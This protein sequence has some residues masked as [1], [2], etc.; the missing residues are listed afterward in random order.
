MYRGFKLF[1]ALMVGACTL[2]SVNAQSL[3]DS[4]FADSVRME[5]T[6]RPVPWSIQLWDGRAF[7][8]ERDSDRR[9]EPPIQLASVGISALGSPEWNFSQG[10]LG[11]VS[12][13]GVP[14]W[15]NAIPE[16][17]DQWN[18]R[19]GPL[20]VVDW[21]GKSAQGRGQEFGVV[22]SASPKYFQHFWVDFRRLQ[23]SGGLLTE[24]H[25]R[26]RLRTAFWGRDSARKWNYSIQIGLQRTVDGEAG[27]VVDTRQ[28]TEADFWQPNRD[29]VTTRWSQA[30]RVGQSAEVRADWIHARSRLGVELNWSQNRS[31]FKGSGVSVDSVEY[32]VIDARVV[33]TDGAR[34]SEPAMRGIAVIDILP[35]VQPIWSVGVRLVN[36]QYW[37]SGVWMVPTQVPKWSPVGSYEFPGRRNLFRADVD[38][39]GRA[40]EL[41][42]G[43]Q[44]W[45]DFGSNPWLELVLAQRWIMPWQ[46][47]VVSHVRSG[48]LKVKPVS[49]LTVLAQVSSS[50]PMLQVTDWSD[51]SAT[52]VARDSW[53]ML[54]A[55]AKV[56]VNLS[57][58]WSLKAHVQ[59]RWA[60][61]SELGLAPGF[62]ELAVVYASKVPNLY[63]G[64]RVQ[65]EFRGQGWSGG[66]QRPV[67]V[68]EKGLFGYALNGEAMPAGGLVHAAAIVYLGEAQLGVIAQ[69][70]NQG[71]VPNTVFMAQN[72]PV[73]PASIRW[74][75]KW[76]MFE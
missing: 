55:D 12:S 24:D 59:G 16:V 40:A 44:R 6:L 18:V 75:V 46:G 51:A 64:M 62:G 1:F 52:W 26:D 10:L 47:T 25:F 2:W 7:R 69:N 76:R 65:F 72:Y 56:S 60:S 71:W 42:Y 34:W 67:W 21:V 53:A 58:H 17:P 14:Y 57:S 20:P 11:A 8:I 29:L 70:A 28:L 23:M 33:R 73:P 3:R 36:A 66:W 41:K 31:G 63:P 4:S 49:Q 19:K 68:A 13:V 5:D 30:E 15:K 61:T 74:F 48:V 32:D 43:R 50:D 54:G 35:R 37:E 38:V 45:M 39:L 22:A 9:L 27:G